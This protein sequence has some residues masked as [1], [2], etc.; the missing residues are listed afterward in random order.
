MVNTHHTVLTGA[1]LHPPQIIALPLPTSAPSSASPSNASSPDLSSLDTPVFSRP[2]M[3][4]RHSMDSSTSTSTISSLSSS[5]SSTTRSFSSR[6][7]S[8]RSSFD[9]LSL[10]AELPLDFT[11]PSAS[12]KAKPNRPRAHSHSHSGSYCPSYPAPRS[13][14]GD[15]Y[16][17]PQYAATSDKESKRASYTGNYSAMTEGFASLGLH[18]R[19]NSPVLR[20]ALGR[21]MSDEVRLEMSMFRD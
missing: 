18:S 8:T 5:S 19:T 16:L 3:P 20:P 1:S 15:G 21:G 13:H 7:I 4:S 6:T 17:H 12:S 2:S 9:P 10:P 14:P 11:I